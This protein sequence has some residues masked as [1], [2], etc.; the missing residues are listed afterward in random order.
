MLKYF[1]LITSLMLTSFG[2]KT[3]P[4]VNKM[5]DYQQH[6][7]EM[8]I[9]TGEVY[10]AEKE[11]DHYIMAGPSALYKSHT[12]FLYGAEFTLGVTEK[13]S[14]IRY[15]ATEDK[16][17]ITNEGFHVGMSYKDIKSR[18]KKEAIKL[19]GWAW[20]I[21]LESGWNLAFPLG[22]DGEKLQDNASVAW[23]YMDS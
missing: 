13:E 10:K 12:L 16:K 3:K 7:K 22:G 20:Y 2:N 5:T 15:I 14:V 23:I 4:E 1:I 19:P 6:L 8:G 11:S 18:L 9:L 21:P 17:F